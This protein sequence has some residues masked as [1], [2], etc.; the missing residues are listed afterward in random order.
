MGAQGIGL[1]E[2]MEGESSERVV[3]VG[4]TFLN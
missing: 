3:L 1:G 4:D 2:W